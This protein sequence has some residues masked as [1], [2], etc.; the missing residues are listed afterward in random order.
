MKHLIK[1][2]VIGILAILAG[3]D[4]K[5]HHYPPPVLKGTGTMYIFQ[6]KDGWGNDNFHVALTQWLSENP[7]AK[8][9]SID[10]IDLENSAPTKY[11]VV[12]E[13]PPQ[14]VPTNPP[15]PDP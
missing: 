7:Q 15:P 2:T 14:Q 11:I 13:F 12:V 10:G 3:C 6:G 8:L 9:I 1:T 5:P 4:D